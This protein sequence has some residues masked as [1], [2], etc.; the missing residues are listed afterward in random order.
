M[1]QIGPNLCFHIAYK[2]RM[3]L[4]FSMEGV[5]QKKKIFC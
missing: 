5:N 1:S 3:F 2:L 4:K